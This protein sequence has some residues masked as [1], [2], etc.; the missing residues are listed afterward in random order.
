MGIAMT[1]G[2]PRKA[3]E[4]RHSIARIDAE[5]RDCERRLERLAA[6]RLPSDMHFTLLKKLEA[7]RSELEA[8]RRP[9][10]SE[11]PAD[12]TRVLARWRGNSDPMPEPRRA[13]ASPF[14]QRARR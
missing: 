1:T 13:A 9:P 7:A 4:P 12:V 2:L 8:L 3:A 10:L 6:R 5:I 11:P 14:V